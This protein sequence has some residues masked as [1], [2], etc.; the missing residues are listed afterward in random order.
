[1]SA[2]YT[3]MIIVVSLHSTWAANDDSNAKLFALAAA[4]IAEGF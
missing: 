1:M 2:I 4:A 3:K